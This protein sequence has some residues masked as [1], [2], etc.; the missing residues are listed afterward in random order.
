MRP[1]KA[2]IFEPAGCLAEFPPGPFDE[3]ALVD[4]ANLYEDVIPA[5]S[6]LKSMGIAMFIASSLSSATIVRFVEHH[7]LHEFFSGVWGGDVPLRKAIEA[8]QLDPERTIFL[9]DTAEGLKA[10]K[11]AGV[12]PILMMNDPD[13]AQR[14]VM[15]GPAGGIVSLHELPDFVRLVGK[16]SIQKSVPL[17]D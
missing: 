4:S 11:D 8:A 15:Q 2:I 1:V 10:A 16:V 13:K 9:T 6:E 7:G 17:R 12:D 14:L 5:L 3:L